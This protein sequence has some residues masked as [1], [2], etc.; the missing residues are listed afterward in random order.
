MVKIKE[1]KLS[2]LKAMG[3]KENLLGGPSFSASALEMFM[4]APDFVVLVGGGA[5]IV[6]YHE[7]RGGKSRALLIVGEAFPDLLHAA[8]SSAREVGTVKVTMEADPNGPIFETLESAGYRKAGNVANY[9]GKDR[10]AVFME[11]LL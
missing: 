10:P 2:D 3:G 11:K 8:E 7:G 6:L 9:F 1:A 4:T 5:G